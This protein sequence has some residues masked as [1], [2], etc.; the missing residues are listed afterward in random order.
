MDIARIKCRAAL[1]LVPAAV[2]AGLSERLFHTGL[3]N[4]MP[5]ELKVLAPFLL[6]V[7]CVGFLRLSDKLS[8]RN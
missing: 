1:Y 6:Y 4:G 7:V 5:D 8:S 3:G 2:M